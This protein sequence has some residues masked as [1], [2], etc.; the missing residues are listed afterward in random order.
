MRRDMRRE[1]YHRY[2]SLPYGNGIFDYAFCDLRADVLCPL[3]F[4]CFCCLEP[5]CEFDGVYAVLV[6]VG[7][8]AEKY[9]AG[10]TE[11]E[12]DALTVAA[13]E[14]PYYCLT[15]TNPDSFYYQE[16]VVKRYDGIDQRYQ[17]KHI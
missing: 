9:D 10:Y 8:E 15:R 4:A 1:V 16:I 7:H 13:A 11:P 6:D 17:Y 12:S 2:T 3:E 14:F 5:A